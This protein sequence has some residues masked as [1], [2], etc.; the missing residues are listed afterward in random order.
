MHSSRKSGTTM[1]ARL[2]FSPKYTCPEWVV[3]AAGEAL[4]LTRFINNGD[5][6]GTRSLNKAVIEESMGI[7]MITKITKVPH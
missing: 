7:G 1:E 4:T 5:I 3:E 6:D 2:P